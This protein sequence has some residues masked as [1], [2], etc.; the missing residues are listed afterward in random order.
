MVCPPPKM[1]RTHARD[2]SERAQKACLCHVCFRP[3]QQSVEN[4]RFEYIER[5]SRVHTCK[6]F[7]Y[8]EQGANTQLHHQGPEAR[9][10]RSAPST[11]GRV[12]F[13]RVPYFRG[14][15]E[16]QKDPTI[17]G[18]APLQRDAPICQCS[19]VL[20]CR[21]GWTGIQVLRELK[22]PAVTNLSRI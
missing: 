18:G 13:Q 8:M 16:N 11:S 6:A 22:A 17:G 1:N 19:P 5:E 2:A 21:Y 14:F 10:R 15:T 20:H 7:E 3:G 12:L 4:S 9:K